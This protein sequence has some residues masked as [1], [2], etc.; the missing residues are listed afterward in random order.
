MYRLILFNIATVSVPN[1]ISRSPL[2]RSFSVVLLAL[3]LGVF[4]L[5][6][7]TQ[8]V[9]PAPDGG[10]PNHNTAEGDNALLSLTTGANN[11][12]IGFSAL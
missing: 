9:T 10:Y 4:A 3:A 7:A 2:R 5:L 12:A 11:T 1:L 8:A 6:P